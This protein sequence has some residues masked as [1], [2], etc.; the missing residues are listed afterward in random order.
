MS[1]ETLRTDN[2]ATSHVVAH[3]AARRRGFVLGGALLGLVAAMASLGGV[4]RADVIRLENNDL[5]HGEVLGGDDKV[6]KF[7]HVHAGDMSIPLDKIIYIQTDKPVE[8]KL[9]DGSVVKAKLGVGDQPRTVKVDIAGA[10]GS[11]GISLDKVTAMNEPPFEVFWTGRISLGA[12]IQNGN[13]DA[14]SIFGSADFER[15]GKRDRI[16]LHAIYNY[17]ETEGALSSRNSF[18]RAQYSY[19]LWSQLYAYVGAALEYD[20][21]KDLELRSRGGGGLGFEV[22]GEPERI[23]RFEAGAEYVNEDLR[24]DKDRDFVVLRGALQFEIQITDWLRFTELAEYLP[25]VEDFDDYLLRSNS[26]LTVNLFAGFGFSAVM[27]YTRDGKP[28][29]DQGKS[30]VTYILTLT[31]SF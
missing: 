18:V 14:K 25:D 22:W 23:L 17:G 21:F 26:G 28:A 31:Y 3:S 4:A 27:I 7:K 16:Q 1:S 12:T 19:Y 30:D 2:V 8:M 5:L 10:T 29:L 13:T 15:K 6:V 11:T 9:I 20:Y 24:R